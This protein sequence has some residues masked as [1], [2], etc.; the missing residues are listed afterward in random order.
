MQSRM[1]C[2]ARPP[3]RSSSKLISLSRAL[4]MWM[5]SCGN[6]PCVAASTIRLRVLTLTGRAH[7]SVMALNL[8][9]STP[10]SLSLRKPRV[11]TGALAPITPP[12]W[13]ASY[14]TKSLSALRAIGCSSAAISRLVMVPPA[15]PS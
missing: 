12:E 11:R 13:Q 10:S 4:L 9:R 14:I 6:A 7:S 5:M 2:V 3:L 1:Y 8:G 15:P